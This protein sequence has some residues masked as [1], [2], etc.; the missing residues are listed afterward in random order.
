[1]RAYGGEEIGQRHQHALLSQPAGLHFT[2]R[3]RELQS[4]VTR[5]WPN[6]IRE[7]PTQVGLH[8]YLIFAGPRDDTQKPLAAC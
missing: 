5:L 1:M 8:A 7:G 6:R 3:S 2:A 4:L